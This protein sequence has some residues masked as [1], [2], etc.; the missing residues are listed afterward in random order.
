MAFQK[1]FFHL[2]IFFCLRW[3]RDME[4][5]YLLCHRTPVQDMNFALDPLSALPQS[6]KVLDF[7]FWR[8][9]YA[10]H[11]LFNFPRFNRFRQFSGETHWWSPLE[12]VVNFHIVLIAPAAMTRKIFCFQQD[13]S[14]VPLGGKLY[15]KLVYLFQGK[16]RL[17]W[18]FPPADLEVFSHLSKRISGFW[19]YLSSFFLPPRFL[20]V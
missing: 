5:L 16:I 9:S 18:C 6:Q 14:I 2:S 17:A 3:S 20:Y 4:P 10:A 12:S 19:L 8:F 15:F 11:P 1:H 13:R 7:I